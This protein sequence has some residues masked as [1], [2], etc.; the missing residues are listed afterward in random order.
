MASKLLGKS[1]NLRPIL[2]Y[3]S[4]GLLWQLYKRVYPDIQARASSEG[5]SLHDSPR[6]YKV[7]FNPII[8]QSK[9]RFYQSVIPR[10]CNLCD[11][12]ERAG[13]RL[14]DALRKLAVARTQDI[15][16]DIVRFSN[17]KQTLEADQAAGEQHRKR[18]KH[19]RA[20]NVRKRASGIQSREL[21][22]TIDFYSFLSFGS[23]M[24]HTLCFVL[25]WMKDGVRHLK[26][27]G[28]SRLDAET[29]S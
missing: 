26:S 25:E 19:Q 8:A 27:V 1:G 22:A 9:H 13:E 11:L 10:R 29:K 5:L 24:V 14:P 21:M 6:S 18:D 17:E 20:W 16:E 15:L 28:M 4:R 3:D 2:Y 12:F 7:F 23:T